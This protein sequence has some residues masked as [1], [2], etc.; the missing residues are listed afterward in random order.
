[1]LLWGA[2]GRRIFFSTWLPRVEL[3]Y[4]IIDR[5]VDLTCASIVYL[6]FNVIHYILYGFYTSV[7]FILT[8]LKMFFLVIHENIIIII[9][10]HM[11]PYPSVM[12]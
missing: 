2:A 6:T 8:S 11:T 9:N 12:L 4:D 10:N 7:P 1:M 5:C 3:F